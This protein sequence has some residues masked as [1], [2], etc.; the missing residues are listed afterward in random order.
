MLFNARVR[1]ELV[2]SIP[3]EIRPQNLEDA[4]AIQ[5]RLI[6]LLG[7]EVGGWFCACTNETI[8]SMLGLHEPY[9]ARLLKGFIF[10]S[11]VVLKAADYPPMVLEC[12]FSFRLR[13]DLSS[14]QKPYSR[15]EVENA[16]ASVHPS[17]EVVAGYLKDWPNQDVFSII[18]DNGTDGALVYG[19]G[20]ENWTSL[21][22]KDT[23][24]LLRVNGEVERV[25]TG[26]NVLGDPIN[27]LVWL[28]N[29]R[30]RDGNG[31]RKG[32]IHNTGTATDIIWVNA[33]DE[34]TA[35]FSEL[36]NVT[37]AIG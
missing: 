30:S 15:Q 3:A 4:Y 9:Y 24:V 33:G 12:E 16:I 32:D 18:A 11:G 28:A 13:S 37:L 26:A 10:E 22:F 23:H 2:D 29:A 34:A 1:N 27:A 31:L 21:D 25:G 5:K 6:E 8:Q 36:G 14:R 20:S 7:L 35:E 17:I 19:R